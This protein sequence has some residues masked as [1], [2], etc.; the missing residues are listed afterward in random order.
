VRTGARL[1][2]KR[3]MKSGP[4]PVKKRKSLF[5][6]TAGAAADVASGGF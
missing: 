5:R 3:V 4:Q 2:R 1:F 6:R